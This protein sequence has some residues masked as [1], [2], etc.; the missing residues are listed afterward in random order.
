MAEE[1]HSWANP[2]FARPSENLKLHISKANLKRISGTS[3]APRAKWAFTAKVCKK[4]CASWESGGRGSERSLKTGEWQRP[5]CRLKD[6][7]SPGAKA[8]E[9]GEIKSCLNWAACH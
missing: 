1:I 2:I 8:R 6:S 4:N 7:C 9:W 3:R 5:H